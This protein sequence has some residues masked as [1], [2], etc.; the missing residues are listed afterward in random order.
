MVLGTTAGKEVDGLIGNDE[1]GGKKHTPFQQEIEGKG[2]R[3]RKKKKDK[4]LKA[5]DD[6][7]V[8]PLGGGGNG[9]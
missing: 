5:G 7:M 3:F 4:P 1:E 2:I 8:F 6:F 9:L